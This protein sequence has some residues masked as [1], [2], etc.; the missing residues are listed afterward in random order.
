MDDVGSSNAV[1]HLAG[2]PPTEAMLARKPF[3]ATSVDLT[4]RGRSPLPPEM[5]VT[6]AATDGVSAGGA[7]SSQDRGSDASSHAPQ[8]NMS[9]LARD[10]DERLKKQLHLSNGKAPQE[11]APA[12][13]KEKTAQDSH[14]L[15]NDALAKLAS[16]QRRW[17]DDEEDE[18]AER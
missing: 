12:K 13:R 4:S 18:D 17:E 16:L 5:P 2:L 10:L 1:L 14:D 3:R 15:V 6:A 8:D 11:D 9:L 7:S